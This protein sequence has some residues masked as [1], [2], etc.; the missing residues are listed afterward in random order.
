[1]KKIILL[2]AA[3][4]LLTAC[5]TVPLTGRKQLSLVP[6]AEVLSLSARQYGDFI[7]QT[8]LSNDVAGRAAVE[9]VGKRI[10]AAVEQYLKQTGQLALLEGYA[11]EFKLVQGKDVNAFCM[12]GGKVVF[13]DG[14]MPFTQNDAGIATVMGHEI[15]HAIAR[16]GNERM[17]QQLV[18]QLGSAA[19][20]VAVSGKSETTQAI[21]NTVFGAGAQFGVLLPYSRKHE[22]EADHLGMIFMAMAGYNPNE[23]IAFWQRMAAHG[24]ANVAEFMSTHP[25][26]DTRIREMKKALPEA[27]KYYKKSSSSSWNF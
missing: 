6:N 19:T 20:A 11:W 21:A 3:A 16:H 2:Y 22:L 12:P 24:G 10:Q 5:S 8:P 27:M 26:D 13:Y 9:R 14:I 18:A 4:M 17:S 1:M 15:A 7:K 25:S 23:A